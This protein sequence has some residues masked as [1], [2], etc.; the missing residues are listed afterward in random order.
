MYG[1]D[2]EADFVEILSQALFEGGPDKKIKIMIII[3]ATIT[4]VIQSKSYYGD[5]YITKSGE[6]YHKEG[7]IFV[8]DK[9]NIERLTE[10]KYYSGEYEACQICLP[11]D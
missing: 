7:C 1:K 2:T 8:K 9:K 5:Y 11:E 3:A 10:E 4:N 6:K